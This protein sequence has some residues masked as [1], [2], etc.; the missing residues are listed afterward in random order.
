MQREEPELNDS[1]VPWP[2]E[3]RVTAPRLAVPEPP[4]VREPEPARPDES[5]RSS[6]SSGVCVGALCGGSQRG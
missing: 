3:E 6:G 1:V 2:T 4:V 5:G